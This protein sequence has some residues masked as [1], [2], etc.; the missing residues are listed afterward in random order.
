MWAREDLVTDNFALQN[1]RDPASPTSTRCA[2]LVYRLRLSSLPYP[3]NTIVAACCRMQLSCFV[4]TRGLEPPSLAAY[5]SEAY[6]YTNFTTCPHILIQRVGVCPTRST[7]GS[8]CLT[9]DTK[10]EVAAQCARRPFIQR[11]IAA[12]LL[13]HPVAVRRPCTPSTPFPI[14][15]ALSALDA[16]R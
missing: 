15:L 10:K 2:R 7:S 12:F 6:V 5:A 11:V 13:A 3:Y 9:K 16:V 8:H 1:F 14:S 4:G